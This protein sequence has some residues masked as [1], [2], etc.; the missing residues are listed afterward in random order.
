MEIYYTSLTSGT[1]RYYLG[2]TAAGLA[3]V[4]RRM[5]S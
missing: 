3:F 4:E 5:L 2:S 1:A